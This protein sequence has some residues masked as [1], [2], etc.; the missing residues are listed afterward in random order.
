MDLH[1]QFRNMSKGTMSTD[2]YIKHF[3]SIVEALES[4]GQLVQEAAMIFI[5]LRGLG[6]EYEN[7]V[8]NTN[9]NVNNLKFDDVVAN[10]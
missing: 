8:V 3:K 5:F 6:A 7:F 2:D 4:V 10:P 9:D 1:R